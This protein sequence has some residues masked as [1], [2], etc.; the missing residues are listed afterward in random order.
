[1]IHLLFALRVRVTLYGNFSF[2]SEFKDSS[3][4]HRARIPTKTDKG[5]DIDIILILKK[6]EGHPLLFEL[7]AFSL[8]QCNSVYVL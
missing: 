5:N 4:S 8:V 3:S 2:S 1:M 7:T 6:F